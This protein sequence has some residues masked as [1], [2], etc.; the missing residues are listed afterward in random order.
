M[1]WQGKE[2]KLLSDAELID[3]INSVAHM[4]NFRID[5]LSD[6]RIKKAKHRLNTIFTKHPPVENPA[7]TNLVNELNT[8]YQ[9][10]NPKLP[11]QS[12]KKS[13]RKL[14]NA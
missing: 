11:L 2:V 14:K 8:E 3:A 12:K 9:I 10:R 6:L 4:E 7:Y 1:L 5:K 13:K